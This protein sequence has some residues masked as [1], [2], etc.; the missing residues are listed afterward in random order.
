MDSKQILKEIRLCIVGNEMTWDDFDKIFGSL[1][2]DEQSDIADVIQDDFKI[3]L[4]EEISQKNFVDVEAIRKEIIPYVVD[5][6]LTYYTFDKIFGFLPRKEQYPIAYAIQDDLKI[7]LVDEIIF[8]SEEII[9]DEV[10]T[11]ISREAREIKISNKILIG[12][13]QSGDEQARQDLC[14]KNRGLVEK[15]AARYEKFFSS[16]LTFEDLVQEGIIGMLKAAER[17]TCRRS[18]RQ[19]AFA[20]FYRR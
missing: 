12:L 16:Q 4:V 11:L 7:E 5:N 14:V 17:F 3:S 9:P 13:I 18:G 1:Q 15:F 19:F 20:R 6:K 8:S 2:Q 10:T